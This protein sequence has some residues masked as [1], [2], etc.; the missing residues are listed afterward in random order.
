MAVESDTSP[1]P[2]PAPAPVAVSRDQVE[3]SLAW[4]SDICRLYPHI[5]S[6][7]Y[8]IFRESSSPAEALAWFRNRELPR[9]VIGLPQTDKR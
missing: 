1:T 7:I 9:H 2:A 3:R 5:F 4:V 8:I 6:L